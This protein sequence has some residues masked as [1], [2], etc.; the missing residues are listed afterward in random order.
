MYLKIIYKCSLHD[1]DTKLKLI[2]K[3]WQIFEDFK[4]RNYV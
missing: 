1:P 4:K 2:A 3:Y